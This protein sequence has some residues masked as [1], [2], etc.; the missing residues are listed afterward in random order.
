MVLGSGLGRRDRAWVT[1]LQSRFR[2][3][4]R[5]DLA[6]ARW[7]EGYRTPRRRC[8]A[9]LSDRPGQ[10]GPRA[11]RRTP[12]AGRPVNRQRAV[13]RRDGVILNPT[14][15]RS[16]ADFGVALDTL[17]LSLGLSYRNLERRAEKRDPARLLPAATA[18]DAVRS[19][20]PKWETVEIF[21]D[22]C[23]VP[24]SE[25]HAWHEAWQRAQ[26]EELDRRRVLDADPY[27]LGLHRPIEVPGATPNAL[28]TYVLRD[29]DNGDR[30]IR[31]RLHSMATTG[32]FLLIVGDSSVGK[33]R[34]AYEAIR[35]ECGG[36]ELI[37]PDDAGRL[38]ALAAEPPTKP[39]VIWLD[40]LQTYFDGQTSLTAGTIRSLLGAS[41]PVV[42][43]A[44][45]WS[46]FQNAYSH[47][48]PPGEP[49]PHRHARE[50]LRLADSVTLET[51]FTPGETSRARAAADAGDARISAYLDLDTAYSL[52]EHLAATPALLHHLATAPPY[53]KAVLLA[54][55]DA[56]R[57]GARNPLPRELLLAAADDYCTPRDQ[58]DA[59]ADWFEKA[60]DYDTRRLHGSTSALAPVGAGLGVNTG[61]LAADYLRQHASRTRHRARPPASLWTA[62]RD[63]LIHPDD[64]PRIA[65]NACVRRIY[66][67]A[68]PLLGA[69]ADAGDDQAAHDLAELL[70]RAGDVD[71]LQARADAGDDPAAYRLAELRAD[72]G[73]LGPLRERAD[74]GD[75]AAARR[76]AEL[77][78]QAAAALPV[79]LDSPIMAVLRSAMTEDR[80]TLQARAEAGNDFAALRLAMVL[81][82]AGD[83]DTL[84]ARADAGDDHAAYYLARIRAAAGDLAPLQAC[85]DAGDVLAAR[86]LAELLAEAGDDRLLR[87]GFDV[88]GTIATG[89]LWQHHRP[90]GRPHDLGA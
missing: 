58:A 2:A 71:M 66:V 56:H 60:L 29:K 83:V 73:D 12:S 28:P 5:V 89:P 54:A 75:E 4:G 87:F 78:G 65:T 57:L 26:S 72:A 63:H 19:G 27:L 77:R 36:W 88:D 47:V 16:R 82:K 48:P 17:R 40:E 1:G 34:T 46:I 32:G 86:Y 39:L 25:R 10:R 49:D 35:A 42:L 43:V 62:L 67:I 31:A 53:A 70:A 81:A 50:T 59:P 52:P 69:C 44:T 55:L 68:V 15:V 9:I 8:P 24:P 80:D 64:I 20:R 37:H 41:T 74:A 18:N 11:A 23:D 79:P 13:R 90:P 7:D 3:T 33:S 21:L 85:A 61:Y 22:A 38:H 14:E 76:L 84:Q 45:I 30:G 6:G 51:A